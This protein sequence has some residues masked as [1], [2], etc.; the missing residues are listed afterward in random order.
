MSRTTPV[1]EGLPDIGSVDVSVPSPRNRLVDVEV[2]SRIPH[3]LLVATLERARVGCGSLSAVLQDFFNSIKPVDDEQVE[4]A[5]MVREVWV[6]DQRDA[7]AGVA[8]PFKELPD[9]SGP[10]AQVCQMLIVD[11]EVALPDN[12]QQMV[13]VYEQV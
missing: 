11:I 8:I 1:P 13:L 12:D 2:D 4:V 6:L 3:R 10:D 5:V 7:T 9:L